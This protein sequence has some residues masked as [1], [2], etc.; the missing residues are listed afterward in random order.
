M[1]YVPVRPLQLSINLTLKLL[2][3]QAELLQIGKA[4]RTLLLQGCFNHSL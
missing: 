1:V 2:N 3:K 4:A